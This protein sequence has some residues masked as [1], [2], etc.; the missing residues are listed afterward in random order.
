M[1][2]QYDLVVVGA[3]VAGGAAARACRDAGMTV[4]IVE[5][6]R[7]GGTCPLRGC[8]PKKVLLGA[9]QIVALARGLHGKG[10]R[11]E[12]EVDW[13]ALQAFK[14]GFVDKMP[15][16][17]EAAYSRRGIDTLHGH[18][19]L[20]GPRT[21]EVDGQPLEAGR[22]FLGPG[23]YP[24][25]LGIPGEEFV[26]LSDAFLDLAALPG[27]IVF[28]GGGYIS[29]EFA[30]LA[31]RAG[32]RATV[33]HRGAQVLGGFEPGLA[34]VVAQAS[35][36]AGIEVHAAMPVRAVARAADGSL[37]VHAGPDGAEVFPCDMVVHGAGRVP[38]L[39]GLGLEAA[40]VAFGP[41]GI[42]VNEYMQ[43]TSNPAVY[44][45]GDAASTPFALT[46]S[47]NNEGQVAAHNMIHGNSLTVDQ[48]GIPR[49]VF[50][51]PPLAAVGPTEAEARAHG[52]EV[53]AHQGDM[54]DWLPWQRLG[55]THTGYKILTAPDG[56]IVA[57]HLAGHHAEELVNTF[58]LAVRLGLT[59]H[60]VRRTI[61]AYPTSGYYIQYMLPGQ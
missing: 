55:E 49:V 20:T 40:G 46:P 33:L 30:H 24:A 60:E 9:A 36:Q 1:S 51:I 28:I 13:A 54:N 17:I 61:W 43:S 7:F 53:T 34:E 44:A 38:A 26:T 29:F 22:I 3:G 32:A 25:P 56:R 6:D 45:G 41:R 23:A 27:R 12:P 42:L 47:S 37:A 16:R 48:A 11:G 57:A 15:G 18:A 21:L 5:S 59:A 14:A 52:L 2:K 50:S 19:R 35:R 4:A 10:L 39:D 8:N 58:A 31:A